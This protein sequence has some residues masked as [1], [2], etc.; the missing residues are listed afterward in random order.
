MQS[1]TPHNQD[2]RLETDMSHK[3]IIFILSAPEGG[4]KELGAGLKKYLQESMRESAGEYQNIKSKNNTQDFNDDGLTDIHTHND[5]QSNSVHSSP[6]NRVIF[7]PS[8]SSE[9][10][11]DLTNFIND[12]T[13]HLGLDARKPAHIDEAYQTGPKMRA[14]RLLARKILF[15]Y[16]ST[17]FPMVCYHE[18]NPLLVPF[19]KATLKDTDF[20]AKFILL[21]SNP[22]QVVDKLVTTLHKTNI[23]DRTQT[24][25][26]NPKENAEEDAKQTILWAQSILHSLQFTGKHSLL[27]SY[28]KFLSDPHDILTKIIPHLSLDDNI[29]PKRV[30]KTNPSLNASLNGILSPVMSDLAYTDSDVMQD[31]TFPDFIKSLYK[32]LNE[33]NFDNPDDK[34]LKSALG[35]VLAPYEEFAFLLKNIVD[36]ETNNKTLNQ[37]IDSNINKLKSDEG[38]TNRLE[39]KADNLENEKKSLELEKTR[40]SKTIET[41]T[42]DLQ[43]LKQSNNEEMGSLSEKNQDLQAIIKDNET[44]IGNLQKLLEENRTH[45]EKQN[46]TLTLENI[47]L[48]EEVKAKQDQIA[49]SKKDNSHDR[50]RFNIERA[51]LLKDFEKREAEQKTLMM[52][53]VDKLA[54][55]KNTPD[56]LEFDTTH[57]F[58]SNNLDDEGL[59]KKEDKNLNSDNLA[60]NEFFDNTNTDQFSIAQQVTAAQSAQLEA[61]EQQRLALEAEN[62]RLQ[63]HSKILEQQLLDK[64]SSLAHYV[65]EHDSKEEEIKALKSSTSW[66]VSAP[67]RGAK[68]IVKQPK[69]T[70]KSGLKSSVRVASRVTSLPSRGKNWL[71]GGLYTSLPFIFSRTAS[72]QS[73][74]SAKAKSTP[75]KNYKI[76][77]QIDASNEGNNKTQPDREPTQEVD[78]LSLGLDGYIPLTED[79]SL[80]TKKKKAKA[81]AFYLPQYHEIPENDEWWGKGF[82]EWTNVK[83]ATPQ[84]EG[85]YQPHK[86]GELGYYHLLNDENILHRQTQLAKAHGIH[87]F[88]FYFYWFAG[89]R[90]L[91][92][93]LQ[94]YLQDKTIDFPFCLC[95]ANENW[96]RRWNGE[97]NDILMAQRH[98]PEDDF[99][100][101]SYLAQYLKDPRY[102]KIDGKPV[103]IV[104]RPS[105]LPSAK[106][107]ANRWRTWCRENGI[108]EI[109]LAY[110]QSFDKISPT[111]IN[112]DAAIEF[113]PNNHG[114]IGT[115]DLLKTTNKDFVGKLFDWQ[116]LVKRSENYPQTPYPTF[117]G[118]TPSWDNTARRNNAGTV[119]LNSHPSDYYQWLKNAVTDTRR[120]FNNPDEQ[121]VF[122]NAWNEW[123][124]GAHLEPDE[125]HGYAWLEASK[126]A[127]IED[128][129]N[130][131]HQQ[132]S[133][134]A[135]LLTDQPG[136][137]E[138][139]ILIV[140]HDLYRHG[141]QFLSLNFARVLKENYGYSVHII[142]CK[143][144]PLKNHFKQYGDLT[145][146][147]ESESEESRNYK[148]SLIKDKG[149]AN[150][151]VNSSASGWISPLLNNHGIKFIGLV[152]EMQSI[153]K[154]MNLENNLKAFND[155]A[156]RVIFPASIVKEQATQ[157]IDRLDWKS[158]RI[159]SQGIYKQ[160]GYSNKA[161]QET[162]RKTILK[163]HNIPDTAFIVLGV[164]FADH[165]KGIDSFL[166]M[167]VNAINENKDCH[168]IWVGDIAQDMQA[169]VDSII[170]KAGKAKENIHL[171]GFQSQTRSY[172]LASDLFALTS[173]EDPF[174]STALE[175]LNA[176]TPVIMFKGTGGIEDLSTNDFVTAI[177]N[178]N[179]NNNGN[180]NPAP[181][182]A[183]LRPY[184]DDRA[185]SNQQGMTALAYIRENFGFVSYVGDLLEELDLTAPKVSAIIP[186]YNYG[187]HLNTRIKSVINQTIPP[188]EIIFLDD[189]STDNSL[190]LAY[191][192]LGK[193]GINHK[194][195][196]NIEN[197]GNVFMQWK[198]GIDLAR[199]PISWIAEADDWADENFI[200]T[201]T[202]YFKSPQTVIAYSESRQ[203]D[204]SGAIIAPDYQYYVQ[205]ISPTKWQQNFKGNGPQEVATALNVKNTIP[206][207]SGV[208]FKTEN[209]KKFLHKNINFKEN[210]RA[211]GDWY[212][213]VNLLREGELCFDAKP[214]NYHRRHEN[215]VTISQFEISDL[216]EIADMQD[217]IMRE[218]NLG[219]EHKQAAQSYLQHLI[220]HFNM[221]D[222]YSLEALK[223]ATQGDGSH[224]T[225]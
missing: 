149:Y 23:S 30:S 162:A 102:I 133:P 27:V 221:K 79:H 8:A 214:L 211:A 87:G 197:S 60:L 107:T 43:Q 207:V 183:A 116:D 65:L 32:T 216:K 111:L 101:I 126:R 202:P 25:Q 114:L 7:P 6:T 139:K 4:G 119:L 9:R 219:T 169:Q 1:H 218:F 35:D 187:K 113:P 225:V 84:F 190:E 135:P 137:T 174:P 185:L 112:F 70:V 80:H 170:T 94:R 51:A 59:N 58:K 90:L 147:E 54:E 28:P 209:L 129:K 140:T 193:S 99:N 96:S 47:R 220:S 155:H 75:K 167:A 13:D 215:S 49:Q 61:I 206:N 36:I 82:T 138:K 31:E 194:I 176:A 85:H 118:V 83:K 180:S 179:Q 195:I 165:R 196:K 39:Q 143:D 127:L 222:D 78:P 86:P 73:W 100:F 178:H 19:W 15:N 74:K 50:Q 181:F 184:L 191:D 192:L 146:I 17:S 97:E 144:G 203:I 217:Y 117:R 154:T 161:E 20:N 67:I 16:P 152:H 93:P 172:Y 63:E 14:Q 91:E 130:D 62:N 166:D 199:S 44:S 40:L 37:K 11:A 22:R 108:G 92:A 173:R 45:F 159:L 132:T 81:I 69:T 175:S 88:A 34:K 26:E 55:L 33:R 158:S 136:T 141:A 151:F 95:W 223:A 57:L 124:E 2:R 5:A 198:K 145:I 122:I 205:D 125:K 212:I 128:P 188:R 66:K 18:A 150:A 110:T 224:L 210:F 56:E 123:A 115:P 89:K 168:F 48:G 182:I 163:T 189:A 171:T 98:S 201:L 134:N 104:Y 204:E 24:N 38:K 200:E 164:G 120:R 186:N 109:Y 157:F 148:L 105:T 72:Y 213:Y 21:N 46:Q 208:L 142:A 160:E 106:E 52:T 12:L 42:H 3:T 103:I 53:L 177:D 64:E 156:E 76:V 29:A 121:L 153:I 131:D 41:L 77:P 71:K 68:N 10:S